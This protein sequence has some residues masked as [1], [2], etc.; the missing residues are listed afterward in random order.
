M[1]QPLTPNLKHGVP[2]RRRGRQ[3]LL[4]G[5]GFAANTTVLVSRSRSRVGGPLLLNLS[6]RRP[7]APMQL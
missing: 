2:S 5:D 3:L 4:H 7:T 1:P 6:W